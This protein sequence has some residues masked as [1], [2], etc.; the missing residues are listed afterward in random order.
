MVPLAHLDH[1]SSYTLD[2][3]HA[4]LAHISLITLRT[5]LFILPTALQQFTTTLHYRTPTTATT[6]AAA[7][8]PTA[9][10]P[11]LTTASTHS[12]HRA[13]AVHNHPAPPHQPSQPPPAPLHRVAI[14]P[15]PSTP[16]TPH[17]TVRISTPAPPIA[18]LYPAACNRPGQTTGPTPPSPANRHTETQQRPSPPAPTS[19][20]NTAAY[21]VRILHTSSAVPASLRRRQ[22]PCTQ[23]QPSRTPPLRHCHVVSH[24]SHSCTANRSPLRRCR[25][26]PRS[27]S[28]TNRRRAAPP[29]FCHA[30]RATTPISTTT[31]APNFMRGRPT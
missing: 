11:P 30:N 28:S 20:A 25:R 18:R 21:T 6:A 8:A 9:I 31:H 27:A 24:R 22:R 26:R 19:K 29:H 12:N 7:P 17:S 1:Y 4:P 13:Q 2:S 5:P 14:Q 3:L 10:Q 15:S 23:V 16:A